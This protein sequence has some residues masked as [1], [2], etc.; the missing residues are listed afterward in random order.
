MKLNLKP[1]PLLWAT[2]GLV[3]AAALI[4]MIW[5]RPKTV[6]TVVVDRG[7]VQQDI[8]DEGRTR[9]HDVFAVAAPVAGQLQRIAVEAGDPVTRGQ[10]VAILGPASPALLD[11]RISAQ[12]EAGILAAAAA[13]RSADADLAL[14]RHN[15]DRVRIL[16]D[17][18]YA[19]QAALDTAN[20]TVDAALAMRLSRQ[21]ALKQA[22]VAAGTPEGGTGV[23]TTV[24]SP[25]AGRVLQLFQQSETVVPAGAP[26]LTI[27]DPAQIEIVAEFLSQDAVLMK[28]GDEALVEGWGGATPIP[29]RISR[30]EP[31]AHTKVSALGV[32]EQRVNVIARLSHPEQ[33]PP[34][35]HGFRVDLR[36]IISKQ[37]NALR[38]PVD[39]L[40]RSGDRWAVFRLI[41]GKAML[42][43][44]EISSGGNR[45]RSVHSGLK[46]GD[47]IVIFPGD[48]LHSGDSV[49]P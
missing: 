42:T 14:A 9:I 18:G 3:L 8:V 27:G 26:L 39:S 10:T 32:E 23:T 34:L 49:R 38:V 47:R 37:A 6:E 35:G 11:A 4:W 17:R 16:F 41:D 46:A 15:R 48:T 31:Y 45:Y 21:A 13:L 7:L 22:Q 25:V 28:P 43:P 44:V 5:P 20:A 36:V 2:A 24:K 30:I 1:G 19:S 40:V 29:A 12:S 33:A